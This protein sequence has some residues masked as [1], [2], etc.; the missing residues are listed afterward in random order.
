MSPTVGVAARARAADAG[1]RPVIDRVGPNDLMMLATDSEKAPMQVAGVLVF[2][3]ASPLELPRV[4]E[5]VAERIRAVPRFRQRLVRVPFGCGR[6]I[7]V[8]DPCFDIRDHVHTTRCP[9]PGEE[10]ALLS[11][12]AETAVRRLPR[13][14][15]LWSLTLVTGLAGGN[16][17]MI[18]VFHHVLADGIGGLAV[19]KYLV[20]GAPTAPASAFPRPFPS[21]R[22]LFANSVS[23]RLRAWA[24]V[25]ASVRRLPKAMSELAPRRIERAPPCSL[26]QPTDSGRALGVA[27]A[28]LSALRAVAHAHD[29]TINDVV[30]AAVAGALH[31]LL[32]YRGETVGTLVVSVPVSAR[33][34]ASATVLGNQSGVMP[35]PLPLTGDSLH[36]LDA[37]AEITR[38]RKASTPGASAVILGPAFR[39]L[40]RLGVFEWFIDRQRLVNTFVTN[41]RGPDAR[42]SFLGAPV[43]DVIA[44]SL[45]AGNVTVAFT[46]FS[47]AGTLEVTAIAD[48]D[49]CPDLP[50][51]VRELQR[52]LDNLVAD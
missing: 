11:V 14:R 42:L 6:P 22:D 15:P 45:I 46:V 1:V 33:R 25:P 5:A 26:N 34:S 36:R 40:A 27:R 31:R 12:A 4:R 41:L 21:R 43:T 29:A 8:D 37:I 16:N 48:P 3:A 32:R 23:S 24:H 9:A 49:H 13:Q 47:Y 38:D 52:E 20:D 10:D 51:L 44:I 39:G 50:I 19:L 17:A 7:W 2:A 18:V 28:R 35:V 30:L